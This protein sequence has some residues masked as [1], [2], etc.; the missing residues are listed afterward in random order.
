M[1]YVAST[2]PGELT[3]TIDASIFSNAELADGVFF[4]MIDGVLQRWNARDSLP[5][6]DQDQF[7]NNSTGAS[8]KV[9]HNKVAG[10]S[11]HVLLSKAV[12]D[13]AMTE[14]FDEPVTHK[15]IP[16]L[17]SYTPTSS[18]L[19]GIDGWGRGYSITIPGDPHV[20]NGHD[21][22]KEVVLALA[23]NDTN[24]GKVVRF[25]G[26]DVT[27]SGDKSFSVQ[28]EPGELDGYPSG[29]QAKLT[30]KVINSI[31]QESQILIDG[32][33]LG[34]LA[35][36]V[37]PGTVSIFSKGSNSFRVSYDAHNR[38]LYN[39]AKVEK[40]I[41]RFYEVINGVAGDKIGDD[42]VFNH[43]V[44]D[45]AERE[46]VTHTEDVADIETSLGRALYV[47]TPVKF[48]LVRV[49]KNAIN[50]DVEDGSTAADDS[51][52]FTPKYLESTVQEVSNLASYLTLQTNQ[53]LSGYRS[54]M[55]KYTNLQALDQ[56]AVAQGILITRIR[57]SINSSALLAAGQIGGYDNST[58]G[59]SIVGDV[60]KPISELIERVDNN[61]NTSDALVDDN[62]NNFI[63]FNLL[64]IEDHGNDNGN[65]LANPRLVSE[66]WA[67]DATGNYHPSLVQLGS[68]SAADIGIDY[69]LKDS[70]LPSQSYLETLSALEIDVAPNV[71]ND[72]LDQFI[73][74]TVS[75]DLRDN[76][77]GLVPVYGSVGAL[78]TLKVFNLNTAGTD[79]LS[80]DNE[81]K[82]IRV[83][84]RHAN[85]APSSVKLFAYKLTRGTGGQTDSF[86]A[87]IDLSSY[88]SDYII[89]NLARD[90]DQH[91]DISLDDK[92]FDYGAEYIL[93]SVTSLTSNPNI[94]E[95]GTGTWMGDTGAG[96]GT[97]STK[98]P[99]ETDTT[100]VGVFRLLKKASA[101]T[102]LQTIVGTQA[103]NG[104]WS[105]AS[106]W[107]A[108]TDRNTVIADNSNYLRMQVS[109]KLHNASNDAVLQTETLIVDNGVNAL[110][111][112]A[113]N[114]HSFSFVPV[115][116]DGSG[117]YT[118]MEY[119]LKLHDD[120]DDY[121]N[122]AFFGRT[123]DNTQIQTLSMVSS[124]TQSGNQSIVSPITYSSISID[125]NQTSW[126]MTFNNAA[127]N[128]GSVRQMTFVMSGEDDSVSDINNSY[129]KVVTLDI[130]N[131]TESQMRPATDTLDNR[132][133]MLD[134]L[135]NP[136]F[137]GS[138]A[139]RVPTETVPRQNTSVAL[140]YALVVVSQTST[141]FTTVL[142]SAGNTFP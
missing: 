93:K 28:F 107:T 23:V 12:G 135:S 125:Q 89:D 137:T 77:E 110:S 140:D 3:F 82:N 126:V 117:F 30:I 5:F 121:S 116:G 94:M 98:P 83:L 29:A 47:A 106:K 91:T 101:G 81:G 16:D 69:R 50:Q 124:V 46:L 40:T 19:T 120:H 68:V 90:T 8:F 63:W 59:G 108:S 7:Y 42:I 37:T 75:G 87:E 65:P 41:M 96:F 57:F 32:L 123:D 53:S 67:K 66:K 73:A 54:G 134:S 112:D 13:G 43:T 130:D 11:S 85:E 78:S 122:L 51:Y 1:S 127:H 55:I 119:Q 80:G 88:S 99:G 111:V 39:N 49:I 22:L 86:G 70:D 95:S 38:A 20:I 131:L 60:Y 109:L 52:D 133:A 100:V 61:D 138:Y 36:K 31:D 10:T 139:I 115:A 102:G 141:G 58:V 14:L 136:S 71:N 26:N 25:T 104:N 79:L 128:G 33:I 62:G 48:N 103:A 4:L 35:E 72:S 18:R 129:A 74:K 17:S 84:A 113:S 56:Y 64:R 6:G 114:N 97:H 21:D 2:N 76:S 132:V 92:G 45:D 24:L 105:V 9:A 15:G 27:G 34:D 118:T 44:E 142:D